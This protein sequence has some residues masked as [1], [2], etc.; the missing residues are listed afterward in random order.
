MAC[1]CLGGDVPHLLS[2]PVL[3]PCSGGPCG[4]TA[5]REPLVSRLS[6]APM[7]RGPQH[8]L[9]GPTPI[10]REW[11]DYW[12][13]SVPRPQQMLASPSPPRP[14]NLGPV[15]WAPRTPG[16]KTVVRGHGGC[17]TGTRAGDRQ[18]GPYQAVADQLGLQPPQPPEDAV[19][20]GSEGPQD[21]LQGC[22]GRRLTPLC[23]PL[24]KRQQCVHSL[25]C[26]T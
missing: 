8:P 16:Q 22:P 18:D 15:C 14:P 3:V 21:L 26:P 24:T 2:P 1:G 13:P 20:V 4:H 5:H 12:V 25:S 19:S 17:E 23:Q 6:F 7:A 11:G 9:L 10:L